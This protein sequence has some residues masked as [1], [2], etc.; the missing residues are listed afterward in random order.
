MI[1]NEDEQRELAELREW[2]RR[3]EMAPLELAF[4]Q[5][6]KVLKRPNSYAFDAI[7]PVT[8]YRVLA[9]CVI[10]LKEEVFKINKLP[11]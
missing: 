1:L 11:D 4:E 7:M 10:K 5:L 8:A 9:E 3:Q 2:K 6:D